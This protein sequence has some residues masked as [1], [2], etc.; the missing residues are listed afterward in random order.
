M[1]TVFSDFEQ[2]VLREIKQVVQS[3]EPT[4]EVVLFGSRSRGEAKEDSDFDLLILTEKPV[5]MRYEMQLQDLIYDVELEN[6]TLIEA[7]LFS[8]QQWLEG[9]TPSPLINSVRQ[10]GIL[11]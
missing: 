10:E 3:V 7:F 2:R 5:S 8:K 9:A 6:E 1:E 4:A 11:V